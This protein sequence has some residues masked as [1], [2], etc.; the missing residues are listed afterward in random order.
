[1]HASDGLLLFEKVG[2]ELGLNYP[3][4]V[5][6]SFSGTRDAP[7]HINTLNFEQSTD[8]IAAALIYSLQDLRSQI[9]YVFQRHTVGQGLALLVLARVLPFFVSVLYFTLACFVRLLSF[10]AC[11]C[12]L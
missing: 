1:M 6:E 3:F 11:M 10:N 4:Y 2:L 9:L 5:S 7:L 8:H 12:E